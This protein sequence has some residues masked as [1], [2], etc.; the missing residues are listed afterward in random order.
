[1]GQSNTFVFCFSAV[2]ALPTVG[3]DTTGPATV[4][5]AEV[6]FGCNI[7]TVAILLSSI[8]ESIV[9]RSWRY[10]PRNYLTFL[11]KPPKLGSAHI[12]KYIVC[13]RAHGALQAVRPPGGGGDAQH[14]TLRC[15]AASAW[16]NPGRFLSVLWGVCWTLAK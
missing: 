6:G 16:E 4:A 10:H 7:G 3:R 5:A 14:G 9:W 8:T 1:M 12:S 13:G 2:V 15:A 11:F